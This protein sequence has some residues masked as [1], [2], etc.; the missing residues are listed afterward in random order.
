MP[1]PHRLATRGAQLT[2]ELVPSTVTSV[3]TDVNIPVVGSRFSTV[4]RVSE[5]NIQLIL[6]EPVEKIEQLLMSYVLMTNGRI[7]LTGQFSI[8]PTKECQSKTIHGIRSE[9]QRPTTCLL[10]GK[11]RIHITRAMVPYSTLLVYTFQP[12]V[13]INVVKSYRFSVAGLFQNSLTLEA[14]CAKLSFTAE[15]GSIVG[16]NVVEYDSVS[17]GLSNDMSEERLLRCLTSYE[18]HGSFYSMLSVSQPGMHVL[19]DLPKKT[20]EEHFKH[21][22]PEMDRRTISEKDEEELIRREQVF[23]K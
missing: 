14:T 10:N 17:S 13:G 23:K 22:I 8:E 7:T 21:H 19:E 6:T 4:D 15:P 1:R 3:N 5:F 20:T 12:T 9:E 11:L 18:Q 16:L 2:I